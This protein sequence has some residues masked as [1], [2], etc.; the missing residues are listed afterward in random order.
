MPGSNFF[1]FEHRSILL[2]ELI[3]TTLLQQNRARFGICPSCI[4][5]TVDAAGFK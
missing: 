1:H 3:G 2:S 5:S 4:A